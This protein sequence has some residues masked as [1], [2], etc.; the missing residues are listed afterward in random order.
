[1]YFGWGF[2][3]IGLAFFYQAFLTNSRS[4][5]SINFNLF[6]YIIIV[7]GY[8]ISLWTTLLAVSLNFTLYDL[9]KQAPLILLLYPTFTVCRILY[10]LTM[11]CGYDQ[12]I[13]SMSNLDPELQ[14]CLILLFV[15]PWILIVLGIYLYEVR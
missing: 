8:I 10:Y 9:P 13:S 1:M 11:K 4:A 5:T 14:L 15:M 12:C 2:C 7:I 6:I 3:Q